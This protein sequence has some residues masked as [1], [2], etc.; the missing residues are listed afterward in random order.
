[1]ITSTINWASLSLAN[2]WYK[3]CACGFLAHL[4]GPEKSQIILIHDCKCHPYHITWDGFI[5]IWRVVSNDH[6]IGYFHK[7]KH[8]VVYYSKMWIPSVVHFCPSS[9][10]KEVSSFW[11]NRGWHVSFE[12]GLQQGDKDDPVASGSWAVPLTLA[13]DLSVQSLVSLPFRE[14]IQ[15]PAS[16]H[17]TSIQSSSL[18]SFPALG[19]GTFWIISEPKPILLNGALFPRGFLIETALAIYNMLYSGW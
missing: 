18:V 17:E 13:H 15:E 19:K 16:L 6:P 4:K 1:M 12:K 10:Y 2:H 11:A 8:R 7:K 3:E 5:F 9:P 14:N